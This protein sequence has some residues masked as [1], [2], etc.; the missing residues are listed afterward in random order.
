MA[1]I[2]STIEHIADTDFTVHPVMV[3]AWWSSDQSVIQLV[4]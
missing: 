3:L 1:N 4:N 2:G